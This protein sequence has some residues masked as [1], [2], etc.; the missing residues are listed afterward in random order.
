MRK[1][2]SGV[3]IVAI[4]MFLSGRTFAKTETITGKVIDQSCYVKDKANNTGVDHKMPADTKDCAIACAKKGRPMALLTDDG[5]V[6]TIAGDLA[7]ENNAKLVPHISHTVEVIG[8]VMTNTDG[9]MMIHG[10]S[11][12]MLKKS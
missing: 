6:Y 8:D 4:I 1:V 3:M 5:K 9:S 10:T 7:A 2:L 11:L 12:R